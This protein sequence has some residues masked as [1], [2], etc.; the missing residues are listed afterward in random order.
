MNFQSSTRQSVS[1]G[2]ME[3]VSH[4]F[5]PQNAILWKLEFSDKPFKPATFDN[6]IL[7]SCCGCVHRRR[8]RCR[9]YW[10]GIS[11][12]GVV[13]TT[14][15]RHQQLSRAFAAMAVCSYCVSVFAYPVLFCK[16]GAACIAHRD[17]SSFS[18]QGFSLL[19]LGRCIYRALRP[20][21]FYFV[22]RKKIHHIG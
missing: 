21:M 17:A 5:L 16:R 18:L 20:N 19:L 14:R 7:P 10:D 13:T 15:C 6:F 3:H 12:L 8:H 11:F 1:H 2:K 22:Q 4:S 9:Y